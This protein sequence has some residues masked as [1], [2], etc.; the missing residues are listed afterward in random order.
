MPEFGPPPLLAIVW[1]LIG[2]GAG[3]G[4]CSADLCLALAA[5]AR[6]S[7]EGQYYLMPLVL[8]TMPLT[9]LPMSPGVELNLGNSLI[10]VT[11]IVLLLRT[12]LE[13]NYA[14]AALY[15]PPVV[16]ITLTCC[17]LAVRWAADQFNSESVLF[18]ESE[19]LDMGR[20]LR[21]LLRDRDDT[22]SVAEALACG[23]LILMIHF[24]MSLSL[25]PMH[26]FRDFVL[27]ALVVQLVVIL[28]PSLLM[29]TMLT[30]RPAADAAA[31]A[32]RRP[33]GRPRR[34][35]WPWR[36]IRWRF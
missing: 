24:F 34:C 4:A 28:T 33:R 11:G 3:V 14:L 32:G 5:L 8:V 25:P 30:R 7:K 15:A 1:L 13:G 23:V 27:L 16:A 6:S 35:C 21:N 19:R 10:P 20:W 22:P 12:L 36:S 18:R 9:I 2:P 31:A 26:G 17:L 29:T